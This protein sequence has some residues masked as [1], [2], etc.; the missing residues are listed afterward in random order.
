MAAKKKADKAETRIGVRLEGAKEIMF[1]RIP[2]SLDQKELDAWEAHPER[3]LY[4]APDVKRINVLVFPA[5]NIYS[6]LAAQKGQ[7]CVNVWGPQ[8]PKNA[9]KRRELSANIEAFVSIEPAEIP[10]QRAGKC[11]AFTAFGQKTRRDEAAGLYLRTMAPRVDKGRV[12]IPVIKTRPILE[13]PWSLEFQIIILP[14]AAHV[15][16]AELQGFFELGGET[17]AF[18]AHRPR[19]GGFKVERFEVL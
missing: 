12:S 8:G 19:F 17:I 9:Q 16:A 11:I 4:L 13:L 14:N 15:D 10:F 1:D 7:S 3:K 5:L 2:P 18:G 6:F